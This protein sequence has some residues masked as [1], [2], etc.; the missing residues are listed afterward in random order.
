MR[1]PGSCLL[2]KAERADKFV[3]GAEYG[4]GRSALSSAAKLVLLHQ[5]GQV[6]GRDPNF[7]RG[8]AVRRWGPTGKPSALGAAFPRPLQLGQ[9]MALSLYSASSKGAAC[10]TQVDLLLKFKDREDQSVGEN[11]P[12]ARKRNF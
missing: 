1:V 11:P 4:Q 6:S 3:E 2:R 8:G 5:V 10:A 12:T 9:R 7:G